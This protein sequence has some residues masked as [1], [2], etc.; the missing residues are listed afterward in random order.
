MFG[1]PNKNNNNTDNEKVVDRTIMLILSNLNFIKQNNPP[2]KGIKIENGRIGINDKL[3]ILP[4]FK[5][6]S[7]LLYNKL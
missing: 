6:K 2:R 5:K 7:G 4:K 1:S 3:V